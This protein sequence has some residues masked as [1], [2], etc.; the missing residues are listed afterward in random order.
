MDSNYSLEMKPIS[1]VEQGRMYMKAFNG[2]QSS[3]MK[4][5]IRNL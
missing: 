4:K 1:K 2:S 3:F 5:S